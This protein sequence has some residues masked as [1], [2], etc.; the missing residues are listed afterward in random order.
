VNEGT[1]KRALVKAIRAAMPGAVVYRHEDTFSAGI[2]DIS[3]T[4]QGIT[5]W[6]EVKYEPLGRTSKPT[7]LQVHELDRLAKHTVAGLITYRE[8]KR[9]GGK[10][11]RLEVYVP[12]AQNPRS[13]WEDY[14][15]KAPAH[16]IRTYH[17]MARKEVTA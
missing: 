14:T 10:R 12:G 17:R 11:T 8:R 7:A 4:W 1:L 3:V 15:H 6:W 13:E 5:S 2:P 9:E 16:T